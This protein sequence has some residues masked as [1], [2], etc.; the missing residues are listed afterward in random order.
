[1]L[2]PR[3]RAQSRLTLRG[4][5]DRSPPGLSALGIFQARVLEQV[6]ISH[7]GL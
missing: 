5:T 6:G 7:L 2:L 4:P 1:M 3:P